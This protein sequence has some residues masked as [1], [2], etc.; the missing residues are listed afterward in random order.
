METR[1]GYVVVGGFV[2]ALVVAVL[3]AALWVARVQLA[4]QEDLYDIYFTGSVTGLVQ[5]GAVRYN[6]IPVGRI[7][8]IELDPLDPQRVRV[9]VEINSQTSIKADVSAEMSLQGL[10]GGAFIEL[11]GGT[12]QSPLLEAK[13]GERYPVIPSKQSTLQRVVDN[14]PEILNKAMEVATH[15]NELLN[16]Q[17]RKAVA[18]TLAN[19]QDITGAIADRSDDITAVLQNAAAA[20]KELKATIENANQ[21]VASLRDLLGPGSDLRDAVKRI[22]TLAAR[23]ADAGGHLDALIQENRP[24][25]REFTQHGLSQVEELLSDARTLVAQLTRLSQSL[26]RDPAR[27]LYGDRH[28]G[29]QPK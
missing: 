14:A 1:A 7:S 9:T 12:A 20:S 15:L 3:V 11:S 8:K 27:L 21:T 29:Y 2:V 4:G 18:D 22:D 25:I 24:P 26:E 5:G 19:V 23:L 17:N 13:A 6:G 28:Q 10:T 16:E